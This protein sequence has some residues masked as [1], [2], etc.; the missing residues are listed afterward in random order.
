M[1]KIGIIG[2]TFNPIHIGHLMLAKRAYEE[3]GLDKVVFLPNGNPPHK[4]DNG[5]LDG[6]L[7]LDMVRLAIEGEEEFTYSDMEILNPAYS[8]TSESL[9]KFCDQDPDARYYFIVGGDSLDYMDEWYHPEEIFKRAVILAGPRGPFDMEQMFHKMND[10]KEKYQADIRLL[11]MPSF[12]ISS[13]W[14]R[15]ALES[16]NSVRYYVPKAVEEY[17]TENRLY[18][19]NI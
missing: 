17:I 5:I 8:Y 9:A 3:Y 18:K 6:Q 12:E 19:K 7:R 16:G 15:Q 13:N 4:N 1:E 14:L 2:G 10:L 11:H